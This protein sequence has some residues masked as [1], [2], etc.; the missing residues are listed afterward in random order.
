MKVEEPEAEKPAEVS[1]KPAEVVEISDEAAPEIQRR[2]SRI[3]SRRLSWPP[4]PGEE[5]EVPLDID[6]DPRLQA[7]V[8]Y[9]DPD[10]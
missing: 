2:S 1:T 10:L 3:W 7:A 9:P 6:A 4:S 8:D 5:V